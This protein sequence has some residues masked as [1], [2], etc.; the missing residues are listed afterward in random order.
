MCN[1]KIRANYTGDS[2]TLP[3]GDELALVSS[4]HGVSGLRWAGYLSGFSLLNEYACG[5]TPSLP[6]PCSM[7]GCTTSR[8]ALATS[9]SRVIEMPLSSVSLGP[10]PMRPPAARLLYMDWKPDL[11]SVST[12]ERLVVRFVLPLVLRERKALPKLEPNWL[13][14]KYFLKKTFRDGAE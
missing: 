2:W 1:R 13:G 9:T 6:A 7:P 10:V 14:L 12:V 5:L 3:S 11:P 8:Y 4:S